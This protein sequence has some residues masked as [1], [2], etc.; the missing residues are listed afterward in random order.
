MGHITATWEGGRSPLYG[1][2]LIG[3]TH[4]GALFLL[5]R[6]ACRLWAY[7]FRLANHYTHNAYKDKLGSS[8]HCFTPCFVYKVVL[9]L[10]VF[11]G[12]RGKSNGIF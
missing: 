1:C 12:T 4:Y 8:V 5:G 6:S 2:V 11:S 7:L 10:R 3:V 9:Y